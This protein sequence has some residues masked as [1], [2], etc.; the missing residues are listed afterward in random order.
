MN[1]PPPGR[2]RFNAT[3]AFVL[4]GLA[5]AAVAVVILIVWVMIRAADWVQ[6]I[7]D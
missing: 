5:G 4:L 7:L 6:N 2:S 1:F 3:A